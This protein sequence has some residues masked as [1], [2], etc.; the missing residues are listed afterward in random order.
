MARTL[1]NGGNGAP[2]PASMCDPSHGTA[3]VGSYLPNAWGLYDMLG[4]VYEWCL[5][6]CEDTPTIGSADAID[7]VGPTTGEYRV[8]HGGSWNGN[9]Q[10]TRAAYRGCSKATATSNVVG[11][12]L[13][14]RIP[15]AEEEQP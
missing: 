5:D 12:R 9:Y 3:K 4:N 7:P 2:A 8:R 1:Q 15:N 14:A 11:F 6:R 13:A 10:Y